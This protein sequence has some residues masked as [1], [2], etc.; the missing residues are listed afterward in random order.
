MCCKA[1]SCGISLSAVI[2]K[3][4]CSR[5]SA[6]YSQTIALLPVFEEFAKTNPRP[7]IFIIPHFMQIC[8]D[9]M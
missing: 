7:S 9:F 8:V 2:L 1:E 5:K 4:V 6:F 3:S